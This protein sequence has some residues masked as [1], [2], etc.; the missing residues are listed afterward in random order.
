MKRIV[1]GILA[2]VDAG[3]TTLC[4][5]LL[6]KQGHLRAAGRVDYGNTLLDSHEIERKRGITVFSKQALLKNSNCEITLL[7][8][9][10]HVD[11]A[12][13]TQRTLQI[14]DA[15]IL[16]ISGT[17][18][19]QSHTVTLYKML[20]LNK[21]PTFIFVNKADVETVNK[22][23]VIDELNKLTNGKSIDFT[24]VDCKA[25]KLYAE[26][27]E[28]IALLDEQLMNGFLK[29]EFISKNDVKRAILKRKIFPCFF[30]SALKLKGISNFLSGVFEFTVMPPYGEEFGAKIYKIEEDETNTRLTFLK[31]TGG[32]LPVK[33]KINYINEV[34]EEISEKADTIRVYNGQKFVNV[35]NAT[36][37]MVCAVTGLKSTFAGGVLGTQKQENTQSLI[38]PYLSY[39]VQ[40]L[41][42]DDISTTMEALKILEEQDPSLC[43]KWDKDLNEIQV[44]VMGEIQLEVLSY[45]L[46]N[47]YNLQVRFLQTGILYKETIE[48]SVTG[49]GH[50]EPLRHYAEVHLRIEPLA[51]G[52][53]IK[54]A[55]SCSQEMLAKNW[56]SLV[57]S[58]LR[59]KTHVGVLTRSPITDVKI[60]LVAGR[61]HKKHTV[62]G[63]FRQASYRAVRQ[64]LKSAKS[65][66]LEPWYEYKLKVPQQFTGKAMTDIQ[67]M[68]GTVSAP[69]QQ[70]EFSIIKGNVPV[71][72]A[73]EYQK[74]VTR[75][76]HGE[77]FFTCG[78]KGYA[79][80][81]NEKEV[82]E[83]IAY[84]S[85]NDVENIAD[86]VFCTQGAGYTVKWW[87]VHKHKHVQSLTLE[88]EMKIEEEMQEKVV[89]R[90]KN[91][92]KTYC[93]SLEFDKELLSIFERTYGP[94]KRDKHKSMQSVKKK[95]TSEPVFT[96]KAKEYET[97]KQYLIVDGYNIIHAWEELSELA[98]DNLDAARRKFID[99][100]CNHTGIIGCE[101]I[102]VFDAYKVKG[103]IGEAQ[104]IGNIH[105]VYTKEA[106]T[107][108][109][110][111]EKTTHSLGKNNYVRVATSD[112]LEQ[113][114]ILGHG[115]L[116]ISAAA[117]KKEVENA[118]DTIKEFMSV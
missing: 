97:D 56:Q 109:M 5:A 10:G 33:Q 9:P 35:K 85:E 31:I 77:G 58:N 67:R 117:F 106:E 105:V 42:S 55:T 107:A 8:T 38:E 83:N 48:N 18:G 54:Y 23:N 104:K 76:T 1:L 34:G 69:K 53:G 61:A 6:Y 113:L 21:I 68:H 103:S 52:S 40:V 78:L 60:T 19:V 102:V 2:H 98:K 43:V 73:K 44:R 20:K 88:Q 63:D 16:V 26:K 62:G 99:I 90:A 45:I 28:E 25:D 27:A 111:I 81:H 79:P 50:F 72:T 84:D 70:G 24:N 29:T 30:G 118:V 93:E 115:A 86:S 75:Y 89:Q 4:E 32:S 82:V 80:C 12:T 46:E 96:S 108:D 66:L 41:N 3:K 101:T 17:Q 36:P 22:Q 59:Q 95:T 15:A 74:E 87:E 65:V 39:K 57:L 7:D 92:A 112:N 11:F 110:Y 116:R 71:I 13:E 14:L 100:M 64:G 49:I 114:I 94:I 37:G 91:R 47:R 51:Q